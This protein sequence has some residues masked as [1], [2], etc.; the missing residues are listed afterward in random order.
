MGAL[1]AASCHPPYTISE[2]EPMYVKNASVKLGSATKDY[3]NMTRRMDQ[4]VAIIK[5]V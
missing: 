4:S 3:R 2:A 1:L 5:I